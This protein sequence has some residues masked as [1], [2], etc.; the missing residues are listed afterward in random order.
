ME[1]VGSVGIEV[2][3]PYKLNPKT[4]LNPPKPA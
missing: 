1:P 3:K 2:R 4:H